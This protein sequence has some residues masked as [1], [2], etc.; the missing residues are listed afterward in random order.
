MKLQSTFVMI[1]AGQK[2]SKPVC[3]SGQKVGFIAAP[4][5]NGSSLSVFGSIDGANWV[6]ITTPLIAAPTAPKATWPPTPAPMRPT[7]IP[8]ALLEGWVFLKLA[9][10]Q[11]EKE[12]RTI[13]LSLIV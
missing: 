7:K 12:D 1:E 10:D 5:L 6:K 9:S 4:V 3:T 2:E 11:T 8:E 13:E